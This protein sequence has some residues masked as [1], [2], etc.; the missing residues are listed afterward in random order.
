MIAID[1]PV[2]ILIFPLASEGLST[3]ATT[4]NGGAMAMAALFGMFPFLL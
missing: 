2:R 1:P 4:R 3:H